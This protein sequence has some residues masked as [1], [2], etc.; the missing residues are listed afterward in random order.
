MH[1]NI[2]LSLALSLL[3]SMCSGK[4]VVG[5]KDNT[6]KSDEQKTPALEEMMELPAF[7]ATQHI[8]VHKAYVVNYNSDNYIPN[9][10]AYELTY[11]ETYGDIKR[12]TNFNA[13]PEL[14]ADEAAQW[15]DYRRSGYDRGHMAPAGDMKWDDVAMT[16]SFYLTNVCP[17]D[18]ALNHGLWN[19]LENKARKWARRDSCLYIV[20]GPVFY[21]NQTVQHIGTERHIAVPHGFFKVFL[22]QHKGEW[23]AIGFLFKN[24]QERNE[25][26]DHAVSVDEIEKLTG[27]DFFH[28]LDDETENRIEADLNP[29]LWGVVCR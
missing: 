6:Q 8:I 1:F 24:E 2:L 19:D 18:S 13:D 4:M 20:C 11:A 5:E 10:V 22:R 16:E 21:S 26:R 9:W 7:D 17:Q 12:K 27:Y 23:Q 28:L 14:S 29:D 15:W 3:L 25:L